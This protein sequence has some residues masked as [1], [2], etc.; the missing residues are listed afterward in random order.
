MKDLSLRQLARIGGILLFVSLIAGGFGELYAP[1]MVTVATD[2]AA[3][4][5]EKPRVARGFLW[6][7]GR[8]RVRCGGALLSCAA[9]ARRGRCLPQCLHWRSVEH[10]DAARSQVLQLRQRR[11]HGVWGS[12]FTDLWIS[13]LHLRLRAASPRGTVGAGWCRVSRTELPFCSRASVRLRLAVSSHASSNAWSG[14]LVD[15]PRCE[16]RGMDNA[17]W[18]VVEKRSQ[19]NMRRN[20]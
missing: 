15:C 10:P 7:G 4:G 3:A 13:V 6:L 20:G 19:T 2:A 12:R 11:A 18:R 8:S 17:R 1:A 16:R 9:S 5:S 14:N